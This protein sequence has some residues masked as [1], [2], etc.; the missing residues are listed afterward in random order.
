MNPPDKSF[1]P[2]TEEQVINLR[3]W[4]DSDFVHPYTCVC[5][6]NNILKPEKDG[7]VCL[8]CGY[9]QNWCYQDMLD[10]PPENPFQDQ[11]ERAAKKYDS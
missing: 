1:A 4:Q 5:D 6:S 2:W 10:G 3:K 7:F 8:V 11:I 9:L